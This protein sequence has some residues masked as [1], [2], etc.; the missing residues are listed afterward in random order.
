MKETVNCL[1]LKF[2]ALNE[3]Q[4]LINNKKCIFNKQWRKYNLIEIKQ[5]KR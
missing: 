1:I 4:Q 5:N 2:N 3:Y